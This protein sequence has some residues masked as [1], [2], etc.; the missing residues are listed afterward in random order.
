MGKLND[1]QKNY[2]FLNAERI[3][4]NSNSSRARAYLNEHLEALNKKL[5]SDKTIHFIVSLRSQVLGTSSQPYPTDANLPT[6]D[7]ANAKLTAEIRIAWFAHELR[8]ANQVAFNNL[9]D[10]MIE[11]LSI[12][13]I[14]KSND[15]VLKKSEQ[16]LL[17]YCKDELEQ[18]RISRKNVEQLEIEARKIRDSLDSI[19]SKLEDEKKSWKSNLD[20]R[21]R[22]L[23]ESNI[24]STPIADLEELYEKSEFQ[25]KFGFFY[26]F[27]SEDEARWLL[28]MTYLALSNFSEQRKINCRHCYSR[29]AQALDSLR[30]LA[31]RHCHWSWK[32]TKDLIGKHEAKV[33]S[34]LK[35]ESDD[36]WLHLG[37]TRFDAEFLLLELIRSEVLES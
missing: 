5:R 11:K 18:V 29:E 32:F 23:E 22:N 34:V 7:F 33:K 3:E 19:K 24:I 17:D 37:M 12:D 27:L 8:D 21:I 28:V 20:G 15:G 1:F 10:R 16:A 4:N 13:E 9:V 25:E 31:D 2:D 14:I 6:F 30:H 35:V 36:I 26:Q